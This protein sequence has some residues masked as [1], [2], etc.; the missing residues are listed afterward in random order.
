MTERF[1]LMKSEPNTFSID[2]LARA[3]KKT[4]SWEGVRNYQVRNMLRDEIKKGDRVLF[5]HSACE[6]PGVV[7]TATVVKEG[8]VDH[9]AFDP[10]HHYYDPKSKSDNPRWYMVDIKFEKKLPRLVTLAELRACEPLAKMQLL[11][12][13]NRLSILP[14]T[15]SEFNQIVELAND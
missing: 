8:Y 2:D 4:T 11:K 12:K 7:G 5:Y 3:P 10:N 9:H 1:W 14:V 6:T 15:E 13:G